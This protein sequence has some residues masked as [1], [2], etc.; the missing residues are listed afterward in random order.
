MK[1]IH[2]AASRAY[3][4]EFGR[5][6]LDELGQRAK[7]CMGVRSA[8]VIS[9]T[10]AAPL[11]LQ[12]ALTSLRNAGW[13]ASEY[14][15]PAGE[16]SKSGETYLALLN[17]LAERHLS[18]AGAL[19]ALGG[20]VTG[21]LTGFAAATYLRGIEYIQV[22]TTLLA[23]VDSSVG[24]KTAIDLPMGKNLVGAFH[25][26]SLVL[27]DPELLSSLPKPVFADGC[28]EVIKYGM[29]GSPELLERLQE[30]HASQQLEYVIAKCVDMKREIVENDEFDTG[31]RQ[32][33]NLGHTFGHAIEAASHFALS[34]G[35]SVAMG[36]RIITRA[37]LEMA[38]CPRAC[39]DVLDTLLETHGL[40]L[41]TNLSAETLVQGAL[42]DKKRQQEKLTLAVP[43][44]LG[45]S[46]LHTIAVDELI[47]WA[48]AGLKP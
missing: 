44:G 7:A 19:V 22:P 45:E 48:R 34:H 37:A 21:D 14:V 29:L 13:Q 11:Y 42:S 33:L 30:Y 16:S 26:P 18:R 25:Q 41:H 36:M 6:L 15:F 27:C 20:G 12:R 3:D 2:V 39:L 8:V 10:N 24:G 35:Q 40:P 23:C 9:E 4:V 32:L 43:C 17:A 28:A 47:H 1:R 31:R 46:M 38:F 5:G